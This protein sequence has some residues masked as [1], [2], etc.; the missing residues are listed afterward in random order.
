MTSPQSE[1]PQPRPA[2]LSLRYRASLLYAGRRRTVLAG[3]VDAMR[4]AGFDPVVDPHHR[5]ARSRS[6]P[7]ITIEAGFANSFRIFGALID[8]LWTGRNEGI[9]RP[10]NVLGYRFGR[11]CR[12][13]PRTR[14]EDARRWAER[15]SAD[16]ALRQLIARSE[17]KDL[18]LEES[19]R[20]R[21][22][23]LQPMAGTIT[24]LYFPPLPPYTVLV[25][26][27]EADAQ[28]ELLTR[29]LTRP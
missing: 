12:F 9:R 14:S 11:N 18:H 15:L 27:D 23:Q 6:G 7:G 5:H 24:A 13:V 17:L 21:T 10:R 28:L 3:P 2:P 19:P 1:C 20:G 4:R 8:T 25:H 29:L 26:P 16:P 22:V